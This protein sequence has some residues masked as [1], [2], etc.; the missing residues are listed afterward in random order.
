MLEIWQFW[1]QKR[2]IASYITEYFIQQLYW[3]WSYAVTA[4]ELMFTHAQS[5]I[6]TVMMR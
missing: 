5:I 3:C 2:I 4:R 1:W 6:I